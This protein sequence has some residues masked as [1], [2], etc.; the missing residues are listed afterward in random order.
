MSYGFEVHNS[1]GSVV[2]DTNTAGRITYLYKSSGTITTGSSSNTSTTFSFGSASLQ[3]INADNTLLVF[4]RPKGATEDVKVY[5]KPINN[6]A[7]FYI[8]SYPG[9]QEFDYIAFELST[10]KPKATSG[11][12]IEVYD[13]NGKVIFSD[14]F[15]TTRVRA[16]LA[17]SGATYTETGTTLYASLFQ[18]PSNSE[19]VEESSVLFRFTT[20]GY[21]LRF[22]TDGSIST[23]KDVM[24]S[25]VSGG[26]GITYSYY[27]NV[28]DAA[29]S[30][31]IDTQGIT[32]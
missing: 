2:I 26:G 4:V 25:N 30:I 12:G 20:S 31:I 10:D 9:N 1:S 6:G 19:S 32:L 28:Y 17:G 16:L 27:S 3:T 13:A 18:A 29:K 24:S 22:N 11:Y 7:G 14:Q 8:Q 15:I 5:G 23:I 21:M